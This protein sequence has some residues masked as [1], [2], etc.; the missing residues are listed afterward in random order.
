MSSSYPL[1]ALLFSLGLIIGFFPAALRAQGFEDQE[2]Y[3]DYST[4][5]Q[6]DFDCVLLKL[7]ADMQSIPYQPWRDQTMRDMASLMT[8]Q[9]RPNM[10]IRLIPEI[11]NPDT[12][13]MTIRSIAVALADT[14]LSTDEKSAI[15][16]TLI[17]EA[18]AMTHEPSQQIALRYIAKGQALSLFDDESRNTVMMITN[19]SQRD[20]AFAE[21]AEVQAKHGFTSRAIKTVKTIESE[22]YR[23]Q[24][25][26]NLTTILAK[27]GDFKAATSVSGL[28]KAP[29]NRTQALM[30]VVRAQVDDVNKQATSMAD[31]QRKNNNA[32]KE[33]STAPATATQDQQDQKSD[34]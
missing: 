2:I 4:C 19:P 30:A 5:A 17:K 22:S 13:A 14:T 26:G 7:Q 18:Q 3:Q 16:K 31:K 9:G 27:A 12:K 28:I 33:T 21:I 23:D 15:Y 6:D 1:H 24:V 8:E 11:Q 32:E 10:A 25:Y 34:D 20:K 29:Y